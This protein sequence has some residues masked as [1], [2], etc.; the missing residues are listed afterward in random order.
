MR[1]R[2]VD[3]LWASGLG[4]AVGAIALLLLPQARRTALLLGLSTG[5]TAGTTI[6]RV[7]AIAEVQQQQLNASLRRLEATLG[8][9][10]SLAEA[11]SLP[12]NPS[13]EL[14]RAAAPEALLQVVLAQP[15]AAIAWLAQRRIAVKSYYQPEAGD[16]IFAELAL[17]LGDKYAN[18][19]PFYEQI[20]RH[21]SSGHGFQVNLA[22]KNQQEIADTTQLGHRLSAYA[23]L[24]SYR[25]DRKAKTIY[26]APPTSG[27]AINFFSGGWFERFAL[28]K[29]V[30]L[31]AA[32]QIPCQCL[33]NPK[34]VL[35]NQDD[36]ELDLLFLLADNQPLWVECKTGDYQAYIT[37]YAEMRK[38]LDIEP[39]RA[40]L[41]VLDLPAAL[42]ADLSELYGLTVAN[43]NTFLTHIAGLL[44]LALPDRAPAPASP[45]TE[46]QA[47][48][49]A[50]LSRLE[51]RPL[52]DYRR[53]VLQQLI[54][55][56]SQLDEPKNLIEIKFLLAQ[57]THNL[58]SK[59]KLQDILNV[60]VRREC[61]LNAAGE[62]VSSRKE[63]IARLVATDLAMLERRCVEG[64]AYAA[65]AS[66]PHYFDS[67]ENAATFAAVVGQPAPDAEAIAALRTR[68]RQD[69]AA[70]QTDPDSNIAFP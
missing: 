37:K 30:G 35:P 40:V 2:W 5:A 7:R 59:T 4:L 25:Y 9:P 53:H 28:L 36:F 45:L 48:L 31:L 66:D 46:A 17:L 15:E 70:R 42:A 13:S 20:K 1:Q 18:V 19:V 43:Q 41:L 22:H 56:V 69:L 32:N 50:L 33:V 58:V 16:R 49:R 57:R 21:L 44:A 27:Q 12:A 24:A 60:L 55:I 6:A 26:A 63:P 38:T 3:G 61:F 11:A 39:A 34:V 10:E 64:Y 51:M 8:T 23:L 54:E 52:P 47:Q 29:I 14:A 67:I 62:V 65:I 68:L